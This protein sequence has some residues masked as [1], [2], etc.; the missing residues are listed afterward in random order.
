MLI[1]FNS[2]DC[3]FCF[4]RSSSFVKAQIRSLQTDLIRRNLSRL[5]WIWALND[6]WAPLSYY[7]KLVQLFGANFNSAVAPTNV[8]HAFVVGGA[9][10]VAQMVVQQLHKYI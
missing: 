10:I 3:I 2:I 4:I 9:E 5:Y 1:R 6:N 8:A 7:E